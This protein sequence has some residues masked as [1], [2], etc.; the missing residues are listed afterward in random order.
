MS[1]SDRLKHT[2]DFRVPGTKSPPPTHLPKK[3]GP[4]VRTPLKWDKLVAT[5]NSLAASEIALVASGNS[6]K[7]TRM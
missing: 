4:Q 1:L 5:D 2:V 7:F 3:L 6:V